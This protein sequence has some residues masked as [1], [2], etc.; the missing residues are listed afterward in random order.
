M[1][2]I[3]GFSGSSDREL[4][5]RM[6]ETLN[7][8]G[9]DDSGFYESERMSLGIRRLSIIDVAGGRQPISNEDGTILVA[10]NGE[11]YNYH[12]VRN[13]L[14]KR[15]HRFATLSDTEVIV[16]AYED[17]GPKC[18]D[19]LGGMFCFALWDE[20]LHRLLLA[21]DR[22][23]MKPLY[24]SL[25]PTGIVFGSEIKALLAHPSVKREV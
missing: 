11:I 2:G 9:P 1:C 25:G 7:H 20:N 3:C 10:F 13:D 4:L 14:E 6:T 22:I 18:V 8:R 12:D 17:L 16:H 19:V 21:R 5:R 24:Y 15:G 23:G